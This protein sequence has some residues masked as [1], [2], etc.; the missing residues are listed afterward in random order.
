L[1][2]GPVRPNTL[3]SNDYV[4]AGDVEI[5]ERTGREFFRFRLPGVNVGGID[6]VNAGI[7]TGFD[8]NVGVGL[9]LGSV[10]FQMPAPP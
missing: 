7:H 6:E 8:E 4:F 2:P 10:A 3:V 5:L 9:V 1:R